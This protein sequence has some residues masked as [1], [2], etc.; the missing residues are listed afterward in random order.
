MC[1]GKTLCAGKVKLTGL[2][3]KPL[4]SGKTNNI[5]MEKK[6]VLHET[7]GFSSLLFLASSTAAPHGG[8]SPHAATQHGKGQRITLYMEERL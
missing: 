6:T 2:T 5:N 4:S 7:E 3:A 8:N 1:F